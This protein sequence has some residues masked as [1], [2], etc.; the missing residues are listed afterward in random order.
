M[1]AQSFVLAIITLLVA[2]LATAPARA[3]SGKFEIALP[4][5]A[6]PDTVWMKA[7]AIGDNPLEQALRVEAD[8]ILQAR[9][10]TVDHSSAYALRI[11]LWSGSNAPV[12]A[13]SAIPG[14]ANSEKRLSVVSQ[15][16]DA[17]QPVYLS[18]ILY[19]TASGLRLWQAEAV[20]YGMAADA[21]T[22][23]RD[24]L[25]PLMAYWGKAVKPAS[26]PCRAK[27]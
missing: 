18:L 12:P 14:Y 22:I 21:G 13:P 25:A 2:S 16:A 3:Q 1:R 6:L 26:F 15:R 20:C 11:E 7:E 8:R 9:G 5:G 19:H 27:A 10:Y 23:A 4:R 24:M 17:G